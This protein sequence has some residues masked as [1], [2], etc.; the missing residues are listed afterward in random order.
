M[1]FRI[2]AGVERNTARAIS[3]CVSRAATATRLLNRGLGL[4]GYSGFRRE[5]KIAVRPKNR[6]VAR[7]AG[8]CRRLAVSFGKTGPQPAGRRQP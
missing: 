5:A 3:T 7:L 2:E 1:S 8:S 6:A 4:Y